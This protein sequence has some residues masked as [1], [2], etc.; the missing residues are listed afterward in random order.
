MGVRGNYIMN[1]KSQI[2]KEVK[3][4]TNQNI[5]RLSDLTKLALKYRGKGVGC[6]E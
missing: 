6:L 5:N 4:N 3:L 1:T 2:D